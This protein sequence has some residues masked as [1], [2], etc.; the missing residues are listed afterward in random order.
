MGRLL[1]WEIIPYDEGDDSSYEVIASGNIDEL[2]AALPQNVVPD[3]D[4][5]DS[6]RQAW[7]EAV[8]AGD[9]A[10]YVEENIV[11]ITTKV[12][13]GDRNRD[14]SDYDYNDDNP[15]KYF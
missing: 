7:E 1:H 2:I 6:I 5:S 8:S 13:K 3:Q 11:D 14:D 4:T 10:V 12:S 15:N 9:E